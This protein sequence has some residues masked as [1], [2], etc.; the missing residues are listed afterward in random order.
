[1]GHEHGCQTRLPLQPT[2]FTPE[3]VA[4][5]SIESRKR[6]V[7]QEDVRGSAEGL[8]QA[9]SLMLSAGKF[10]RVPVLEPA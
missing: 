2:K 8:G 1:M 9:N 10:G 7:E 4:Y 5:R 6:F 3:F